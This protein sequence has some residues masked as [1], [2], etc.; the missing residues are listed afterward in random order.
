MQDV[1]TVQ[2]QVRQFVL[3]LAERNGVSNVASNECLIE[4]GVL[5]SLGL[6]RLVQFLEENFRIGISDEEITVESF[7]TIDTIERFVTSRLER[8][9]QQI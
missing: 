4:Q 6:I 2:D 1:K 3:G 5:D 8:G 7:R 9:A